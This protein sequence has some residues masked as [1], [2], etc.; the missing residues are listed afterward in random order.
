[1]STRKITLNLL[2]KRFGL[3]SCRDVFGGIV[4][5]GFLAKDELAR[6]F[7]YPFRLV[8]KQ[9]KLLKLLWR[10]NWPRI[11]RVKFLFK[12]K[13]GTTAK[14][15][16]NDVL[17]ELLV[18]PA[19]GTTSQHTEKGV[20][21]HDLPTFTCPLLKNGLVPNCSQKT[22]HACVNVFTTKKFL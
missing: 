19:G 8:A 10:R 13:D 2:R 21:N 9:C 4:L 22:N 3:F 15:V 17:F 6:D 18:H 5:I 12:R 20:V 1:M 11:K 14:A 7:G 16:S